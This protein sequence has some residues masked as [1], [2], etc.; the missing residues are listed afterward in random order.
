VLDLVSRVAFVKTVPAG[1][2]LSYNSRYVTPSKTDVATIPIGYADGYRRSFSNAAPLVI[3]DRLYR[4]SGTVCMDQF[5]VDLGP[6]SGIKVGD[7]VVLFGGA[8]ESTNPPPPTA[9]DLAE[10]A[11]TISYEILCGLSRRIPRLLVT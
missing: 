1:T 11:G 10:I 5:L 7:E 3:G 2:A 4:V 8:S 9:D 6:G